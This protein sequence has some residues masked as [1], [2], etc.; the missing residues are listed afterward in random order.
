M[1]KR[2]NITVAT[3]MHEMGGIATVLN[4]LNNGF[5]QQWNMRHV[6]THTN[7]SRLFGLNKIFLFIFALI[8]LVWFLTFYHVGVVHIHI[9]SRGSY[10]R[11]SLIIRLAKLFNAKVILH[12]HGAEFQEFYNNECSPDKQQHIRKTFDLADAVIVLSTQW[13][14]W[15]TT[16]VSDPTKVHV[17]YNAVETLE[18]NRNNVEQGRILF[19]GRLG[20][21][22]GVKD[23]I[24]AF[25]IVVKNH[26]HAR[27][28]LG[29]DGDIDTFK[30]HVERLGISDNVDFLGWV[31]GEQKNLWLSK[32]D[33]YCLPSY[34]EGFPMG[35][36]EAMSANIPV[37]AS[38]A[39]GIPDAIKDGVDGLLI[40]AGDV[41]KLAAHLELMISNRN[42]NTTFSTTAKKKFIKNFSKQAV[43]PE[44]D[45]IYTELMSK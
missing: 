40:E 7:A 15:M 38:T 5:F 36:L 30:Q 24:N 3:G 34:N 14:S 23:L 6:T 35:V 21:R 16:I 10:K 17:V 32:A 45:K 26:P 33:V 43:F 41:E 4:I 39:G 42:L 25:T 9:A 20:E 44:L 28:T 11:K 2:I 22:K 8:K 1:K 19:L 13:Y 27:L 29:G 31:A 18:L 37:V 12:L